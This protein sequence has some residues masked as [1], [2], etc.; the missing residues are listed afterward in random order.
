MKGEFDN[1]VNCPLIAGDS[2]SEFKMTCWKY[3]ARS[4]DVSAD[5]CSS[6]PDLT[7]T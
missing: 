6:P 7:L 1:I 2:S 5:L 4:G 3:V